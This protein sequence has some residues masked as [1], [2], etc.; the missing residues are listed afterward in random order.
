MSAFVASRREKGWFS[1]WMTVMVHDMIPG[2]LELVLGLLCC[3]V[4]DLYLEKR[5]GD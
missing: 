1:N 2:V 5:V 4:W 3:I